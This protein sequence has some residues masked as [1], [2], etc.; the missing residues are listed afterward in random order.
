MKLNII[1][2]DNDIIVCYKPAGIASQDERS[3]QPD[4]CSMIKNHLVMEERKNNPG[5]KI[6]EPY[7]G[8]VH[9]LDKPVEGVIVYGKNPGAA[10][11]LSRQVSNANG[12]QKLMKK[13]YHALVHGILPI[14]PPSIT[15]TMKDYL[16]FDKK[17]N[18]SKAANS[19]QPNAKSAILEY[20]CIEHKKVN[21]NTFSLLDITLITGRHH[22]IRVQ[23][24]NAGFPLVGDHKYG[25]ND[26]YRKLELCAYQLSFEHPN[27]EYKT[28]VKQSNY[29]NN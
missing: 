10:A 21:E 16:V 24:A 25:L 8:V 27:G 19:N 15:H 2:E 1:F 23:F 29:A 20:R 26:Q 22:Q 9:R 4:M 6:A 3:F 14:D 12:Q 5:A 17:S 18:Y 13:K 28:F 7:V 11:C